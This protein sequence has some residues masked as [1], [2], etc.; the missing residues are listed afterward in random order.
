MIKTIVKKIKSRLRYRLILLI[1]TVTVILFFFIVNLTY[2]LYSSEIQKTY[3]NDSSAMLN[4]LG[5]RVDEYFNGLEE[6][7]F[8][9]Y[10]DMLFLPEYYSDKNTSRVNNY[11][12]AKLQNMYLQRSE[13]HSI[14]LYVPEVKE[15]YIINKQIGKSLYNAQN[16]ETQPWFKEL[17]L[18][19][20]DVI[21]EPTHVL[22]QYDERFGMDDGAEVFSINRSIKDE[23]ITPMFLSVNYTTEALDKMIYDSMVNSK[24]QIAVL[25]HDGKLI[26]QSEDTMYHYGNDLIKEIKNRNE[27]SGEIRLKDSEN[28]E[29]LM[30]LYRV[31]EFDDNIIM[32]IVN[33]KVILS[34]A[35]HLKNTIIFYSIVVILVLIILIFRVSFYITK[36]LQ[37]MEKCM[38]EVGQGNFNVS[39][40]VKSIDEIGHMSEIFNQ[41]VGQIN[42]LISEKYLLNLKF[43][44]AQLKTLR[45]QI[46]PHFLYNTLQGIQ[47]AACE[48]GVTEIE[49]IILALSSILRYTIKSGGNIVTLQQEFQN[50][51]NYLEIQKFR[52]EERLNYEIQIPEE[53]FPLEVPKLILQPI[54]ENAIVHG[55]QEMEE[56]GRILLEAR[57]EGEYCVVQVEDNGLGM[58]EEQIAKIQCDFDSYEIDHESE[59]GEERIGL[60]NV[61]SRLVMMFER[62]FKMWIVKN[63]MGGITVGLRIPVQQ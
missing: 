23:T 61:Y 29:D 27:K 18:S 9:L 47:D 6:I 54:V 11:R 3:I 43:K 4:Q 35:E 40:Q 39:L 51:S 49:D 12:I 34:Q 22:E 1:V 20:E 25:N 60:Y 13:C 59:E 31:S 19:E 5:I 21:L 50:V 17:N 55:I 53:L 15:A 56:P 62:E 26:S 42:Q 7:S 14:I 46:N 28:G 63:E 38:Q 16:I 32:Q 57:M 58:G 36:P 44:N 33:T 41:M 52:F 45:A 30:V 2:G 48:S 37:E 24:V 10:A 8:S